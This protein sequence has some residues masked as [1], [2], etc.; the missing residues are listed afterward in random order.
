[1]LAAATAR[2]APTSAH[3]NGMP[4]S[5]IR[6]VTTYPPSIAKTP[7]ARLTKP[8]IPIVTDSP[9]EI[10]Y[11]TI[12]KARPWKPMLI[13]AESAS[14]LRLLGHGRS[15]HLGLLREIPPILP[16]PHAGTG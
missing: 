7:C 11:S 16:R 12:A 15:S 1:M 2:V 4:W 3:G 5:F 10:R 9:T 14:A 8:I 13:A 6:L